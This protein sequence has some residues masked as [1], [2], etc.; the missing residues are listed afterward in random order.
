MHIAEHD[1]EV[2]FGNIGSVHAG[3]RKREADKVF[4]T[5][6]R[7]SKAECGR[8]GGEDVTLFR[9]GEIIREFIGSLSAKEAV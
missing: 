2:I 3:P 4:N 6:V 5:Y 9:D 1:Y 8:A 7:S